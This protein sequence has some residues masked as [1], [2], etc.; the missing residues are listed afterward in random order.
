MSR[1]FRS[2]WWCL[3]AGQALQLMLILVFMVQ[4]DKELPWGSRRCCA[5]Q[6]RTQLPTTLF[7]STYCKQE[8]HLQNTA[9]GKPENEHVQPLTTPR[10]VLVL[11]SFMQSEQ[12]RD[13]LGF[14]VPQ[15]HPMDIL[16][17]RTRQQPVMW[18]AY[19]QITEI[20][21]IISS[22][23]NSPLPCDCGFCASLSEAELTATFTS[24]GIYCC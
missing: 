13:E 5:K 12:I 21:G 10:D 15:K 17:P 3:W 1:I 23:S 18:A 16:N 9:S 4:W 7:G 20:T 22:L 6:R 2:G 8:S 14:W 19:E 11:G 24:A